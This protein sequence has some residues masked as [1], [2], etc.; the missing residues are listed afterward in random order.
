[1]AEQVLGQI[2]FVIIVTKRCVNPV[3]VLRNKLGL[4]DAAQLQAA[5]YQQT[6]FRAL[7]A[8]QF[9][10]MR[11]KLNE[12]SWRGIHR[13]LFRDVYSW[14]GKLRT[15]ELAKGGTVFAPMRLLNG[16]ADQ[17]ILPKFCS[18]ALAAGTD[19]YVF[20]NALAECW[21]ELN[22]LHPFRDGNGRAT[23]I[24]VMALAHRHHRTI[25]WSR[26]DRA[27][28]ITAAKAAAKKDYQPYVRLL[29]KALERW[30]TPAT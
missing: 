24:F 20:V 10:D 11:R 18:N 9:A 3:A 5:E 7:D 30:S 25:D 21:G 19:D 27:V 23:Q 4:R 15:V 6:A 16:Y 26:V 8:I 1:L 12:Q 13:T 14:A 29:M 2:P 22:F 17:Q 28:E